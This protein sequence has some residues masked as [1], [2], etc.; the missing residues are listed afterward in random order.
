[1]SPST[2]GGKPSFKHLPRLNPEEAAAT[3]TTPVTG[4][5]HAIRWWAYVDGKRVRRRSD[6]RDGAYRWDATCGPCGWDSNTGGDTM[7]AVDQ[8]VQEHKR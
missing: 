3:P 8:Q 1:M 7:A 2:D 6:M 5:K 4:G